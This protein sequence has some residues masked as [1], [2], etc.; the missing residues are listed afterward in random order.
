MKSPSST[1]LITGGAGFIA[2]HT[3]RALA[4]QG[5]SVLLLDVRNPEGEIQWLLR[6][7]TDRVEFVRGDVTDLP[8]LARLLR[9]RNVSAVVHTATV[10]DLE[11]LVHQPLT[12]EK[13]MIQGHMNVL[14]AA[15]LAGVGRVVFTSSIAVY[16]P[17]QYEPMDERHPVHLPDEPPTL[18][19]YSSFKLAA[20]SIGLFYWGYHKVDFT[21]LRLSAV[22]GLGMRYPMYVKPMVENS[23][24]GLKTVFAT[25]GD[26]RR[27]Y[28]YVRDVASAV[29]LALKAPAGLSTRIFNISS[30]ERLRK[31]SEAAETV[32]NN[33]P[34][35]QIEIG[36]GLSEL[37]AG[38][39]RNR[40]RLSIARAGKDLGYLPRFSLEEGIADYIRQFRGYLGS[41]AGQ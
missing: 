11:I 34:R 14:E 9:R 4:E 23:V 8:F 35:A 29:L 37:E 28:T 15:R 3:A 10:N 7:V 22:Y 19:S 27:D 1:I 16:A 31:S 32:R 2:S 24:M 12:A 18:A 25:G 33:I 13:I 36:P 40:G 39:V 5:S 17:V 30:G 41:R 26:M 21:A 38:D 20:E 6:P